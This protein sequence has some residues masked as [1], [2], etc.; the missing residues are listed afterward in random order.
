QVHSRERSRTQAVQ[1]S[2]NALPRMMIEVVF[3]GLFVAS[4][5]F[6][7]LE[8]E[9]PIQMIG[10]LSGYLYVGFRLMPGLNRIVNQLNALKSVIPSIERVY[11]EYTT[12]SVKE[13][14][15]DVPEFTF[16]NGIALQDVCFRYLNS[17]KD[18]LSHISLG[19]KKGECIG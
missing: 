6:S 2:L 4:I 15:K 12:V 14:Y 9:N 18:A 8:H 11:H 3:V 16:K 17:K 1:T 5:A 7:C 13:S 19:V 10:I